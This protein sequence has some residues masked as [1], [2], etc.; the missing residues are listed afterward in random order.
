M[1]VQR[2]AAAAAAA[3]SAAL[4]AVDDDD[5]DDD[6]DDAFGQGGGEGRRMQQ[7]WTLGCSLLLC[8]SA[9]RQDVV[10]REGQS[11]MRHPSS[12]HHFLKGV[13]FSAQ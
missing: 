9:K 10:V 5:D 7:L 4:A 11:R 12:R 1:R 13:A 6:D 8:D 2:R 3:A